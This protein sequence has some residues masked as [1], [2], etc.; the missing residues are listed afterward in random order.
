MSA[1][2]ELRKKI[3]SFD[4]DLMNAID[5]AKKNTVIGDNIVVLPIPIT[6]RNSDIELPDEVR[7]SDMP[8]FFD[9]HPD[10]A[11][12]IDA[13]PFFNGN[14]LVG[15]HMVDWIPKAQPFQSM[16]VV[17]LFAGRYRNSIITGST[18]MYCVKPSDI[19]SISN[20]KF[21]KEDYELKISK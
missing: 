8:R 6:T 12:I 10:Q 13:S 15:G 14:S 19:I 16:T 17:S 20:N 2:S 5:W 3:A 1:L 7:V 11:I 4:E 21:K 18:V 9:R